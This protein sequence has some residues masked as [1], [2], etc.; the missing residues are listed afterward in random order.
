LANN[1]FI[2]FIPSHRV[3][4]KY[5]IIGGYVPLGKELKEKMLRLELL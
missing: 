5:K 4:R 1:L 2:V 3:I